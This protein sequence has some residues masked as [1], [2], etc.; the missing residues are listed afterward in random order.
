MISQKFPTFCYTLPIFLGGDGKKLYHLRKDYKPDA[1]LNDLHEAIPSFSTVEELRILNDVKRK[2][3]NK[4]FPFKR[5]RSNFD[6]MG[7][8]FG[9]GVNPQR[10]YENREKMGK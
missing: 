3:R 5:D 4:C 1:Y 2:Y 6:I 8:V 10:V 9:H 7:P